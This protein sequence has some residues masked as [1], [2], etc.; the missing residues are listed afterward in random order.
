MAGKKPGKTVPT[1]IRLLLAPVKRPYPAYK[2]P[3]YSPPRRK[4][5]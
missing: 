2:M 4:K 5:K 1:A 3:V